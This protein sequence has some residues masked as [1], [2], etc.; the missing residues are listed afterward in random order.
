[1]G[2]SQGCKL[3]RRLYVPPPAPQGLWFERSGAFGRPR[4]PPRWCFAGHFSHAMLP[5]SSVSRVRE[6]RRRPHDPRPWAGGIVRGQHHVCPAGLPFGEFVKVPL[7][8]VKVPPAAP[9]RSAGYDASLGCP[10]AGPLLPGAPA[11]RRNSVTEAQLH[12]AVARRA[13]GVPSH[14]QHLWTHRQTSFPTHYRLRR[15]GP[16]APRYANKTAHCQRSSPPSV[17][18]RSRDGSP[19]TAV[20]R[21]RI[22]SRR[23]VCV[24][25]T[26]HIYSC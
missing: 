24:T 18:P 22:R 19:M 15:N 13:R 12:R 8:V 17:V 14:G 2:P 16:G 10:G 5:I 26:P 11:I 4:T 20:P 9:E 21:L 6:R 7:R 25:A 1:M 23:G 3:H